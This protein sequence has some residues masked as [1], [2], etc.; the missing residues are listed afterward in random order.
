MPQ[1]EPKRR[2][3]EFTAAASVDRTPR[4]AIIPSDFRGSEEHDGSRI[5]GLTDPQPVRAMLD[6]GQWEALVGTAFLH[7]GKRA[8]TQP[9]FFGA[10]EWVL[11]L[12]DASFP[13]ELLEA[14]V[15]RMAEEGLGLRFTVAG[16]ALPL[17][18]LKGRF[19]ARQF[20]SADL[21]REP[22]VKTPA[23]R[24]QRQTLEVPQT[25][26][27]CDR[28]VSLTTLGAGAS[29]LENFRSIARDASHWLDLVRYH[30]PDLAVVACVQPNLLIAGLSGLA[31]DAIASSLKTGRVPWFP[32][33]E[34][35]GLGTADPD[36]IWTRGLEIEEARKLLG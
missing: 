16:V 35:L 30:P 26:H 23:P 32:Q 6:P 27:Q 13:K 24:S 4:V 8:N 18:G 14:L 17:T 15:A 34:K 1:S 10:D 25:L 20:D 19:P 31:V 7:V 12:A 3:E 28:L 9:R 2:H 29:T 36:L 11:I 33:A 5:P 21:S 22:M